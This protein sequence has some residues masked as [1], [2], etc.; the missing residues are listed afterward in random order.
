M[1]LISIS[2]VTVPSSDNM[3]ECIVHHNEHSPII[4]NTSRIMDEYLTIVLQKHMY[5]YHQGIAIT[6]ETS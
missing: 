5:M 1:A 2:I 4:A 3:I 6:A